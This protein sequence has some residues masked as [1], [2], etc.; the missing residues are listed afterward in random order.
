MYRNMT[1]IKQDRRKKVR[2]VCKRV[3]DEGIRIFL[4]FGDSDTTPTW[5]HITP[6]GDDELLIDTND[7]EWV[8]FDEVYKYFRHQEMTNEELWRDYGSCGS[9]QGTRPQAQIPCT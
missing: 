2:C 7:S 5:A 1:L 6:L 9:G 3:P 4:A 8:D